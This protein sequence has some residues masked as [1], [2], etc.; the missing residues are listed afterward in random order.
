MKKNIS[1]LTVC[2]SLAFLVSMEGGFSAGYLVFEQNASAFGTGYAGGATSIEDPSTIFYNPAGITRLQGSQA[3]VVGNMILPN[4]TFKNKGSFATTGNTTSL[5]SGGN[6]GNGGQAA[7]VPNLYASHQIN[8]Q[9]YLGLGIYFPFGL[10]TKYKKNWVGRYF[11]VE[12]ELRTINI[13]PVVGFKVNDYVSL[14]GGLNI[15]RANAVLSSA[16]DFGGIG[17]VNLPAATAAA[18]GAT[19]GSSDG[20]FKLKGDDWG[21]GFNLGAVVE[22]MKDTRI[23]VSFRSTV[24]TTL[25]GHANY[26]KGAVGN[27][28]SAATGR[29]VR[30]KAKAD[31]DTPEMLIFG[32]SHNIT[33]EWKVMADVMWTHWRRFKELRIRFANPKETDFV[34]EENWKN[35]WRFAVGTQYEVMPGWTLKVGGGFEQ[36]PTSTNTRSPRIPDSDR[37]FLTGGVGYKVSDNVSLDLGY[38]HFFFK[39]AKFNLTKKTPGLFGTLTQGLRGSMKPRVDIINAQLTVR[40]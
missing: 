34:D 30:T 19:S 1:K 14:A 5:M 40:F 6:G 20:F 13:N 11:G 23:G 22:P 28:L 29:F 31:L 37:T 4:S 21:V 8:E 39:N 17:A 35:A 18:L 27:V 16:I 3:T 10:A 38:G 12:S 32:A 26:T 15:Q 33:P 2:A 9:F 24:S 25:S 7:L 36:S